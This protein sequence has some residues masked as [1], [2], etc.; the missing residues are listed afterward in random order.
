MRSKET[1]IILSKIGVDAHPEMNRNGILLQVPSERAKYLAVIG[2]RQK[3]GLLTAR[4]IACR[5]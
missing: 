4:Q 2:L 1:L 3:V 5:Y